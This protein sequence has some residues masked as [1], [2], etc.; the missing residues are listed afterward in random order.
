[1]TALGLVVAF[2]AGVVVGRLWTR[3]RPS[4]GSSRGGS[5]DD[6]FRGIRRRE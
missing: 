4:E 3:Q 6:H 5:L 1:M 2:G